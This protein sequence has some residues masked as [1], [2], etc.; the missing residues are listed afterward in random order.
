MSDGSLVIWLGNNLTK[1]QCE[2]CL[3]WTLLFLLIFCDLIIYTK[4]CEKPT[5]SE[6]I[7]TEL[8]TQKSIYKKKYQKVIETYEIWRKIYENDIS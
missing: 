8:E 4:I 3:F 5:K 7:Q 2:I 1:L 6:L